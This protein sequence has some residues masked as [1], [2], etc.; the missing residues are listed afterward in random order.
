MNKNKFDIKSDWPEVKKQLMTFSRE[1]LRLAKKG[2]KELKTFSGRG[3]LHLDSA[4]LNLKKEHLYHLIGREY[5]R[6]RCPGTQTPKLKA[7]IAEFRK[8]DKAHKGL[9]R[10]I[11]TVG[12]R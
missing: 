1:A 2:E 12:G 9:Q 6:A 8:I 7:L 4:T 5:I 3:K 11:R 10:G